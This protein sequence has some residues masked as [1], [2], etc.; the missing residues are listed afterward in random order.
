MFIPCCS[1]NGR[2][3]SAAVRTAP[4]TL[5]SPRHSPWPLRAVHSEAEWKK[6]V[7]VGKDV[8]LIY[9]IGSLPV[10]LSPSQ[11]REKIVHP[12]RKNTI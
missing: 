2:L 12:R 1:A 3:A 4:V 8:L 10:P 7:A 5:P 11:Q 9:P 6:R